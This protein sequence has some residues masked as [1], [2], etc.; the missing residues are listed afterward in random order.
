MSTSPIEV[1]QGSGLPAIIG[2]G[3][4]GYI[5]L[6]AIYR[7]L[8]HP[9]R[10]IPGPRLAALTW[11]YEIY[12][13]V[14]L[15]GQYNFKILELHKKYGPVLRINPEEVHIS[16]PDF[17]GDVYNARKRNKPPEPS[18]DIESSVAGT[19]EWDIHKMRRAAMTNFFSPKAVRQLEPLLARKRD[20]LVDVVEKKLEGF[21]S[22]ADKSALNISDL[23]F[24]YCWDLIQVSL[25]HG[26]S[27]TLI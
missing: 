12:Y 20:V 14:F 15:P 4:T 7:L 2:L 22:G 23:C 11:W 24:A 10:K 21:I 25:Q 13:D 26:S 6:G 5:F 27:T 17:L 19:A 18:L 1:L 16:D 9:L 8:L 3:I